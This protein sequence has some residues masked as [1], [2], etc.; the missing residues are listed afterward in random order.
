MYICLSLGRETG[1]LFGV[2]LGMQVH[3]SIVY[4]HYNMYDTDI[5]TLTSWIAFLIVRIDYPVTRSVN[6]HYQSLPHSTSHMTS[7]ARH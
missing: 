4:I 5:G 7:V 3:A 1:N 2:A 6:V